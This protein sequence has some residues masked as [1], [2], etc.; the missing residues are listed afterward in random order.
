LGGFF[1]LAPGSSTCREEHVE[2]V[3]LSAAD[4]N[5]ALLEIDAHAIA[6]RPCAELAGGFKV[7]H[8][9]EMH[10]AKRRPGNLDAAAGY[11]FGGDRCQ[12][13]VEPASLYTC[14]NSRTV[15]SLMSQ[16]VTRRFVHAAP[17]DILAGL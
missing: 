12:S 13:L 9:R 8:V 6:A 14:A 3:V 11:D 16:D 17:V 5:F 10:D 2:H 7:V 1:F 15:A 4:P